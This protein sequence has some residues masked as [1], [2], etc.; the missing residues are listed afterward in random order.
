MSYAATTLELHSVEPSMAVL[1][2]NPGSLQVCEIWEHE[3]ADREMAK[4]GKF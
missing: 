4:R 2:R 3:L 1:R